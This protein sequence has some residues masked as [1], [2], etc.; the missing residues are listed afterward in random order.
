MLIN[1]LNTLAHRLSEGLVVV[2]DRLEVGL[3]KDAV[4]LVVEHVC[5]VEFFLDG[6]ELLLSLFLHIG[7]NS[8]SIG[9]ATKLGRPHAAILRLILG[10]AA[11]FQA[12]LVPV[13]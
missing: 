11:L 4:L 10:G 13:S 8:P 1:G 6:H 2:D 12:W 5:H 9:A 3:G 7:R